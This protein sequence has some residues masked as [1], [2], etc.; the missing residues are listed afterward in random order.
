MNLF[1]ESVHSGLKKSLNHAYKISGIDQTIEDSVPN[2]SE[3]YP[4]YISFLIF[5]L[6]VI[7]FTFNFYSSPLNY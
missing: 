5:N 1:S 6:L 4:T 3:L 7:F 2:L